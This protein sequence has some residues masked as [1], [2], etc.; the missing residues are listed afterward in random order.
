MGS[1]RPPFSCSI[2]RGEVVLGTGGG[3]PW[4][5]LG[6]GGIFFSFL[7][8][9]IIGHSLSGL[10]PYCGCGAWKLIFLYYCL[11]DICLWR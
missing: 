3:R 4:I 1:S 6:D 11:I 8:G 9:G 7:G 2:A 5:T 10:T